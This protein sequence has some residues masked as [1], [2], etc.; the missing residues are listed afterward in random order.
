M[1]SWLCMAINV[2]LELYSL[3][4]SYLSS[5]SVGLTPPATYN[6]N[7][8]RVSNRLWT[9]TLDRYTRTGLPECVVSKM[10]GS[11]LEITQD[12]TQRKHTPS[13]VWNSGTVPATL[14]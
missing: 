4:I 5:L 12:R 6:P 9:I 13:P 10:S 8:R 7:A 14:S 11:P 3:S 2:V 1:N